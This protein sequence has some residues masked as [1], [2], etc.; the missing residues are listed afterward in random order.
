MEFV[1]EEPLEGEPRRRINSA[2]RDVAGVDA[3]AEEDREVWVVQGS[4]SG[5]Q[6]VRAVAAILDDLAPRLRL[7]VETLG[8]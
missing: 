2:L 8:R 4:P 7:H 3:V 5:K 1:R 6:L